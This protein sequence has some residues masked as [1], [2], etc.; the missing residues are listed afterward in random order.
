MQRLNANNL[1]LNQIMWYHI[2]NSEPLLSAEFVRRG[3]GCTDLRH[4]SENTPIHHHLNRHTIIAFTN[5]GV[6]KFRSFVSH[7][8]RVDHI[9]RRSDATFITHTLSLSLSPPVRGDDRKVL[10]KTPVYSTTW[11]CAFWWESAYMMQPHYVARWC[12]NSFQK[13][14][15]CWWIRSNAGV[16]SAIQ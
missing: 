16:P 9:M 13:R 15:S 5:Q 11:W 4:L 2:V 8:A 3:S 12:V 6:F 1:S 7:S 14:K 10:W